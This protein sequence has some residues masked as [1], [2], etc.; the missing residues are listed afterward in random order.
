MSKP[1]S[2]RVE[3]N[4]LDPTER[5]EWE[6]MFGSPAWQKWT[7]IQQSRIDEI[8]ENAWILFQDP[9]KRARYI[10][11]IDLLEDLLQFEPDAKLL[12]ARIDAGED[13]SDG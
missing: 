2:Q 8:K 3:V 1:T 7:R 13:L 5:M 11:E 4:L 10:A 9:D 6:T 12:I